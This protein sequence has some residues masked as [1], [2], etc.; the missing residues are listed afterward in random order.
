MP[1]VSSQLGSSVGSTGSSG[2]RRSGGPPPPRPGAGGRKRLVQIAIGGLVCLVLGLYYGRRHSMLRL[3]PPSAEE[4]AAEAARGALAKERK[5]DHLP[6]KSANA[7]APDDR[8][9]APSCWQGLGELDAVG[10]IE[11]FRRAILAAGTDSLLGSYL[12]QRLTELIGDSGD[13]ALTVIAWAEKAAPPALELFLGA[14]KNAAAVQ[15]P[16]VAERLLALGE[17]AR[18]PVQ[19]RGA[20][21]SALE[22]Q[23][24]LAAPALARLKK[25]AL[26]ESADAASWLATRTLGRVMKNDYEQGGSAEPYLGTLF[27]IG[28]KSPETAVRL[29]AFEMPSYAEPLLEGSAIDKLATALDSDPDASVREMAALQLSVTS[30]PARALAAYQQAFPKEKSACVRWAIFRFTVRVAGEGALPI[31]AQY[32]AADARFAA[33]QAQFVDLS[34]RGVRDF[35]RAWLE[36]REPFEC[37]DG[38]PE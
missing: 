34:Q 1:V 15:Q 7:K 29:L 24:S 38:K 33:A 11:D 22:T 12:E 2:P 31:L 10:S 13:K 20:A 23:R 16:R 9:P 32:V 5:L 26:D 25:V 14:V 21:L 4:P 6:K 3:R 8:L 28:S 18:L 19:N 30:E 27:D 17:D 36:I 37:P 35:A